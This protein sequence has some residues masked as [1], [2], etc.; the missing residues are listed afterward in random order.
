MPE[1]IDESGAD[2]KTAGDSDSE[3]SASDDKNHDSN[4]EKCSKS[5]EGEEYVKDYK[6]Y[7][8]GVGREV[9]VDIFRGVE[10][11]ILL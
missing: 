6:L 2:T 1:I 8:K 10:I 3:Y 4:D 9:N 5:C 11:V 7:H